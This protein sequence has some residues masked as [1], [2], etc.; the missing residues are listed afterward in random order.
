MEGPDDTDVETPTRSLREHVREVLEDDSIDVRFLD[1]DLGLQTESDLD[2][3]FEVLDRIDP[4]PFAVV[5]D[6]ELPQ[7]LLDVAAQRG[8]EHVVAGATGEYVKKPIGVR[9]RTADELLDRAE[10]A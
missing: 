9:V 10:A 4:V 2:G 7:R 6:G 8:V 5:Y 3:A 1:G